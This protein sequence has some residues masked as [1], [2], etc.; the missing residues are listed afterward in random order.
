M[1]GCWLYTIIYI[2]ICNINILAPSRA[3]IISDV[4]VKDNLSD[5]RRNSELGSE[6][7]EPHVLSTLAL[8]NS[9]SDRV[10][11]FS[12][13]MC[14]QCTSMF[15][16]LWMSVCVRIGARPPPLTGRFC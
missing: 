16:P 13:N 1:L 9:L 8:S 3:C 15:F 11:S 2:Y 7:M 4:F 12:L 10:R 14:V 5:L 6:F